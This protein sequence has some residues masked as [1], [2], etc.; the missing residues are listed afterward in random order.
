LDLELSTIADGPRSR[1]VNCRS[2]RISDDFDDDGRISVA[3]RSVAEF[4][5]ILDGAGPANYRSSAD[6]RLHLHRN[7]CVAI[8]HFQANWR[9]DRIFVSKVPTIPSAAGGKVDFWNR[10]PLVDLGNCQW[11]VDSV[12]NV[13]SGSVFPKIGRN[14]R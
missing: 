7:I 1:Q 4:D 6:G 12:C 5:S 9:V 13:C 11:S 2:S 14:D 10:M 8:V 3:G